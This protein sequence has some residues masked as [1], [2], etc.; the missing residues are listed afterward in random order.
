MVKYWEAKGAPVDPWTSYAITSKEMEECARAQG[1][2]FRRG[3]I[4]LLRVGFIR[5]YYDSTRE[6][7]DRLADLGTRQSKLCALFCPSLHFQLASELP[8]VARVLSP[9]MI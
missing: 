5:K 2:T 4:L 8:P 9:R 3:D 7:K 1:V 6:E